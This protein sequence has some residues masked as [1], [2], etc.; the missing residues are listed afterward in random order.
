MR[1]RFEAR[2]VRTVAGAVLALV[3]ALLLAACGGGGGNS[4]SQNAGT[5]QKAATAK[6]AIDPA[7]AKN[8][9]G[10]V[11]M[12]VPKDVSG[13]F[14]ATVKA[15]NAQSAVHA[16]LLELPESADEQ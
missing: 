2:S 16:K 8:A 6:N 11:T 3:C 5:A 15:F 9:K 1:G 7:A 10:S 12:C 4:E 13:A 14:H